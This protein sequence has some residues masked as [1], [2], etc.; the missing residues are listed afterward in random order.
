M[1]VV[2]DVECCCCFELILQWPMSSRLTV[3]AGWMQLLLL[4]L[5]AGVM[6]L[7]LLQLQ[8]GVSG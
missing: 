7:M 3:L 4:G 8:L 6:L 2:V 5:A 1:A